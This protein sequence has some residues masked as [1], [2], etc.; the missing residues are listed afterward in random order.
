M[1]KVIGILIVAAWL[2][3]GTAHAERI[4]CERL[5]DRFYNLTNAV[6]R[7][8][9]V[10]TAQMLAGAPLPKGKSLWEIAQISANGGGY[11]GRSVAMDMAAVLTLTI[12]AN[13]LYKGF[14]AATNRRTVSALCEKIGESEAIE[15]LIKFFKK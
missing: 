12:Y 2:L 1:K 15:E 5:G 6:E 8:G 13:P 14:T 4:D 11:I 10:E 3:A 7:Y 9:P